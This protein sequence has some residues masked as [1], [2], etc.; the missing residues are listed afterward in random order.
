[1]SKSLPAIFNVVFGNVYFVIALFNNRGQKTRFSACSQISISEKMIFGQFEVIF[2]NVYIFPW[3]GWL[4]PVSAFKE[5]YFNEKMSS[6][7]GLK[8]V[9]QF[10]AKVPILA[11]FGYLGPPS[12]SIS[13][14]YRQNFGKSSVSFLGQ[15]VG[16]IVL[17][18]DQFYSIGCARPS[19]SKKGG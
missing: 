10:S 17:N 2:P 8:K 12:K 6:L 15:V 9:L 16:N 13:S 11:I 14:K 1:M 4:L 18:F 7:A 3:R 5:E 19:T